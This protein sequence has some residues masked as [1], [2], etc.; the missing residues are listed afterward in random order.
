MTDQGRHTPAFVEVPNLDGP[1]VARADNSHLVTRNCPNTIEMTEEGTHDLARI[2][3]PQFD[4]VIEATR[5]EQ[6]LVFPHLARRSCFSA[7]ASRSCYCTGVRIRRRRTR[8]FL[9]TAVLWNV[10]GNG[11]AVVEREQLQ[12]LHLTP[13]ARKL[14]HASAE[15]Q[16]PESHGAVVGCREQ[17][18]SWRDGLG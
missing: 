10:L 9:A 17:H 6:L 14:A 16:V 15:R 3:V 18:F 8:Q 11:V 1:I 2:D 4:R 12:A 13:V 5:H 7:S